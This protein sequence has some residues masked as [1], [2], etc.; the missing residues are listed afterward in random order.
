LILNF[1]VIRPAIHTEQRALSFPIVGWSVCSL[2]EDRNGFSYNRE[3]NYAFQDLI[4]YESLLLV[5]SGYK[6]RER[7]RVLVQKRHSQN[8]A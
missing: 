2:G 5:I 4:P 3:S 8:L 6:V 1:S 7:E